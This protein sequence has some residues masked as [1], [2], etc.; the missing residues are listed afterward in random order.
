MPTTKYLRAIYVGGGSCC[1]SQKFQVTGY[2]GERGLS[3]ERLGIFRGS[4][5]PKPSGPTA[6]G[7]ARGDLSD[8]N[9]LRSSSLLKPWWLGPVPVPNTRS[10][11]CYVKPFILA[12]CLSSYLTSLID[13]RCPSTSDTSL[14]YTRGNLAFEISVRY[15]FHAIPKVGQIPQLLKGSCSLSQ[16]PMYSKTIRRSWGCLDWPDPP[17]SSTKVTKL[18]IWRVVRR[19]EAGLRLSLYT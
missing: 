12:T 7:P 1:A 9:G 19:A 6:W 2:R 8:R 16:S 17:C 13:L 3:F 11:T 14:I 15:P 10:G 18:T 5:R 4:T